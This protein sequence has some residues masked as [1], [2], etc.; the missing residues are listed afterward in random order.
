VVD[1]VTGV[2]VRRPDDAGAAAE[3]F[4]ALLDDHEL[5][6]SMG[7]AGRARAVAEYSYDTLARQLGASLGVLA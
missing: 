6:A 7:K 1:G 3:A 5:R 4:V 2:M